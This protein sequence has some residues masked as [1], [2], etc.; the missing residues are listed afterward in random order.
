MGL[1]YLQLIKELILALSIIAISFG[2]YFFYLWQTVL[3]PY[4]SL[5]AS[6]PPIIYLGILNLGNRT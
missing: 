5:L 3:L 2:F 1:F 4:K 6:L